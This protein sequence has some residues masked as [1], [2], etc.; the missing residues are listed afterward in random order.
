MLGVAFATMVEYAPRNHGSGA[1][2][3]E[4]MKMRS[5]EAGIYF[6]INESCL[7]IEFFL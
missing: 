4:L 5:S 7:Q 3:L 6:S 2:H 1:K